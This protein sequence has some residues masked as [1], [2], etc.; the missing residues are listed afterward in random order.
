MFVRKTD[1]RKS[2]RFLKDFFLEILPTD[3]CFTRWISYRKMHECMISA[4]YEMMW[5]EVTVASF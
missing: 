3:Y 1:E 4:K 2:V 5:N